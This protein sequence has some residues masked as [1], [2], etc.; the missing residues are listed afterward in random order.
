MRYDRQII[1]YHA[2]ARSVADR[3]LLQDE[4]FRPSINDW[5][6]L[7]H[8]AYFWEFGHQRAHDWATEWPKLQGKPFAIVGAI[9]QLGHCLDLL[10]TKHARRLAGFAH[11]LSAAGEPLPK[12]EGPRRS[13]DCLLINGFCKA[14]ERDG[15]AYD[16]VRGLFQEGDAI[17]E[18][19]AIRLQNHIQVVVRRPSAVVGL[20]RPRA[21]SRW[22]TT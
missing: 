20:F 10:D 2:C 8:G 3:L 7:G 21:F 18:G 5:D 19:S 4:P 13:L 16:T 6:W 17:L 11:D 15:L 9:I 22:S 12:N 1:G 14:M